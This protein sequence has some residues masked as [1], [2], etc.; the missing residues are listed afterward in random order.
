VRRWYELPARVGFV[1]DRRPAADVQNEYLALLERS[2][3]LRFRS[4]I[5]VG[6]NLSGGL[7]SSMLLALVRRVKGADVPTFTFATGDPGYDELP[8]VERMLGRPPTACLL[9]AADVPALA[10]DVARLQDEPFGGLPTLAY[11]RLFE[12]ARA[13]G[14]AV[15]LDGQGM[16]EQ[17]AGYDYYRKPAGETRVVQGTTSRATRPECLAPAFRA[18][19]EELEPER[20]FG[21]ALRDLQHRDLFQT[22]IPRALRFNDRVS[23]RVGSEL[24]E[25][26]LDHH[27]VELALRQP[28]ARKTDGRQGKRMLRDCAARLVPNET[29]LA[30]KRP[31]QTPQ[32]EWLRGPLRAWV[33][34]CLDELV[35]GPLGDWFD[36]P[37]LAQA[38]DAYRDGEGDNSFFV[39]QWVSA[40]LAARHLSHSLCEAV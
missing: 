12:E 6:V 13:A 19:A 10:D 32:R 27:L 2:V 18:L 23:M 31:V 28:R 25:P 37:K 26:F 29:R 8:W 34:E 21:D 11:A 4:D 39:W 35:R 24:R 36:V 7:D 20:P 15:L 5:P 33:A 16:D 3:R 30:P 38:W 9:R 14:V 17:W 40:T 1:D 22:K